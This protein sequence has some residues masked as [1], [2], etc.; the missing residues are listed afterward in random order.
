M[1][2]ALSLVGACADKTNP[3]RL[4]A[5]ADPSRGLAVI[6]QVGC[7]A[8]HDIPGVGWPRGTVG[9]PLKRFAVRPLI[10]GRFANQP[11]TLVT[12]LK[13]APSLSPATGMP[14]MPITED[15]AR[16]VAAYLYTLDDH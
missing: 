6:E 11:D 16:D 13:D 14:A 12:W 8:C 15:Q 4:I 10:A 2:A 3:P 5:G 9:G 1:I 7:G